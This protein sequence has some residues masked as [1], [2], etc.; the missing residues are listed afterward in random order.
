MRSTQDGSRPCP[1]AGAP[2]GSQ[3]LDWALSV[4]LNFHV[5]PGQWALLTAPGRGSRGTESLGGL[6]KVR[7]QVSAKAVTPDLF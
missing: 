3:A 6:S 1:L 2:V 7:S 4:V 5:T